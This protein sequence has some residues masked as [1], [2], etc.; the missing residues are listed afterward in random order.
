MRRRVKVGQAKP[1]MYVISSYRGGYMKIS[2][3]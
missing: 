2:L 3:V 1:I